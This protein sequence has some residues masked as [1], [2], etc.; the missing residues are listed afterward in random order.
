MI[1]E[2][3][4]E[5]T[6]RQIIHKIEIKHGSNKSENHFYLIGILDTT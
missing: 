1:F 2:S 3:A 6:F 5:N 4:W